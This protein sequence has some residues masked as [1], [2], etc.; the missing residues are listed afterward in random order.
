MYEFFVNV[1][2]LFYTNLQ[3]MTCSH[4]VELN[5]KA[6][7]RPKKQSRRSKKTYKMALSAARSSS[8]VDHAVAKRTTVWLSP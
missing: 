2:A 6:P 4:I 1:S 5:N 7:P 8:V 3:S